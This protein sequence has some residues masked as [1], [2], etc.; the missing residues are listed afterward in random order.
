MAP[1]SAVYSQTRSA[2]VGRLGRLRI[3]QCRKGGQLAA[4]P[5]TPNFNGLNQPQKMGSTSKGKEMLKAN[6]RRRPVS[7]YWSLL[8]LA[9]FSYPGANADW[10]PK[11]LGC[12][13]YD[14]V[15]ESQLAAPV[16]RSL[17][18]KPT[19]GEE[20]MKRAL[21]DSQGRIMVD[22]HL[23]GTTS[24][25]QARN[26]IAFQTGVSIIAEDRA[27]KPAPSR[28]MPRRAQRRLWP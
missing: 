18:R 5:I 17:V 10:I 12:G 26:L 15:K 9:T 22:I 11:N 1:H 14:V 21:K 28:R 3:Y 2:P 19:Q 16:Q 20:A 6:A 4:E 8:L 25:A 23:D 24:I 13:L 27:F 7:V